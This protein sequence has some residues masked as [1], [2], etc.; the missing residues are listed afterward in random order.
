MWQKISNILGEKFNIGGNGSERCLQKFANLVKAYLCY[1][2]KQ[3][4]TGEG[5]IDPP[6]FF[7]EIHSIIGRYRTF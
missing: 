4:K 2:T 7:D 5:K 3:K 1:V 6:Q